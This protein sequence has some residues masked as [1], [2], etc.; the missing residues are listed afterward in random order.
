MTS[1]QKLTRELS[2]L[3]I[4]LKRRYPIASMALFGSYARNEQT[5]N[6]D[7]D[8][9]VEFNGRMGSNFI[10]LAGEIEKALDIKVNLVSKKG[11]K[12]QY[13]KAIESELIYV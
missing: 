2:E 4:H 13:Y 10:D 8:I 3:K 1:T 9:L 5:P 11:I 7:I 12:K 6:S